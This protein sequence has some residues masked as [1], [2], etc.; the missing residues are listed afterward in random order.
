MKTQSAIIFC[1]LQIAA[2]GQQKVYYNKSLEVVDSF[3]AFYYY[4][5]TEKKAD[6]TTWL[7]RFAPSDSL[8][9]Q[10]GYSLF[11]I[12]GQPNIREGEHKYYYRG[13]GAL[14]YTENF[15][16][17][18]REGECRSYYPSGQLKRIE[19]Y[20]QD[21]FVSG[22]CYNEDGSVRPFTHLQNPPSFPGGEA[23]LFQF[24]SEN[25]HYPSLAR[26]NGIQGQVILT[27]V[28]N[29]DGS[30]SDV[31]IVKDIGGGCGAEAKRLVE[32]MPDWVPGSFDDNPVKVRYTLPLK[33]KLEGGRKRK[34]KKE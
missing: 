5:I 10:G 8:L 11:G 7:Q 15:K 18:Q 9:Y 24:L 6:G 22:E 16:T 3:S 4:E 14:H 34:G 20:E 27:F 29:K 2:F 13:G 33:F 12:K 28:V 1:F 32:A 21:K 30:V 19:V 31:N 25:L 23:K 26:E 17:N